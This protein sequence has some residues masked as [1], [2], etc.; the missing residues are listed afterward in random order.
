MSQA[1]WFFQGTQC[2]R[3]CCLYW[4]ALLPSH[5]QADTY[6]FHLPFITA[7]LSRWSMLAA[8][9][10]EAITRWEAA[11]CN[12]MLEVLASPA[13]RL[14]ANVSAYGLS[15][16]L[17][18]ESGSLVTLL[19]RI[20]APGATAHQSHSSYSDGQVSAALPQMFQSFLWVETRTIMRL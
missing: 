8:S 10:K 16:P 5:A 15:V 6:M 18:M 14:A 4:E 17:A 7:A 2:L 1:I 9:P 20:L 3:T 11:W 19:K 12:A 13:P